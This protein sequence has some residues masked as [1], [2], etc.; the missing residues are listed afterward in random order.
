MKIYSDY[1]LNKIYEGT[2]GTNINGLIGNIK[3]GAKNVANQWKG[4]GQ[5]F[6]GA[7]NV[8]KNKN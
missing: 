6:A 7:W 1:F 5:N 4:V 3:T 8:W 2:I